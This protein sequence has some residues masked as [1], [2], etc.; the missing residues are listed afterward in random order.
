MEILS[1]RKLLLD[2][3]IIISTPCQATNLPDVQLYAVGVRAFAVLVGI[4]ELFLFELHK[5]FTDTQT[6]PSCRLSQRFLVPSPV[7]A[8]QSSCR[9]LQ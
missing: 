8:R 6:A 5:F 2:T 3:D 1:H 9:G 7:E 4:R